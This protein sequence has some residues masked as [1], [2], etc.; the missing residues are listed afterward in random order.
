MGK[1]GEHQREADYE[2]LRSVVGMPTVGCVYYRIM[3]WTQVGK[4]IGVSSLLLLLLLLLLPL[5]LP[6][7]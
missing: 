3:V 7:S 6:L 5:L 1:K 4:Y 2:W